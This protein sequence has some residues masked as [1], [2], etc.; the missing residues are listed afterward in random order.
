MPKQL[1]F[2]IEI[3][4]KKVSFIM[5]KWSPTKVITK[6]PVIGGYFGV[7]FSMMFSKQEE[8]EGAISG[9]AAGLIMLFQTMEERPFIEFLKMVTEGCYCGNKEVSSNLD[10]IFE[11]DASAMLE[12][13]ALI[14][15]EHYKCFFKK[16]SGK[17]MGMLG[18]MSQ[19]AA[20]MKKN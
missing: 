11:D 4:D 8:D 6:L 16:G 18:P 14:L 12:L 9:I 13:A 5:D 19:L 17:L 15:E 1:N 2:N 20:Q 10:S 3:E 7:P